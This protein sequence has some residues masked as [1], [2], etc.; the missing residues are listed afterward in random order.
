[1]PEILPFNLRTTG[2]AIYTV[3]TNLGAVYNGLGKLSS[4][5]CPAHDSFQ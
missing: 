3:S 1:M 5:S 2:M 4:S